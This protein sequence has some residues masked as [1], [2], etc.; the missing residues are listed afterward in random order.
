MLTW[1]LIN[2]F[3]IQYRKKN[4][5]GFTEDQELSVQEL[6]SDIIFIKTL[7]H[8]LIPILILMVAGSWSDKKK[9]RRPCILGPIIGE[10]VAVTC[11]ILNSVFSHQIPALLTALAYSLPMAIS[12]GLP[13]LL[14]GV[15]SYVSTCSSEASLTLRIGGVSTIQ[16]IAYVLG[17]GMSGIILNLLGFIGAY[18]TTFFM[19]FSSLIYGYYIIKERSTIVAEV[20]EEL[21]ELKETPNKIKRKI[22]VIEHFFILLKFLHQETQ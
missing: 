15:Y 11:L 7:T 21:Q 6:A 10:L 12:G 19:M 13:C 14:L 17:L 5:S 18:T 4:T 22:Y 8:G 20:E 3:A 16:K 9:S 2:P 1:V